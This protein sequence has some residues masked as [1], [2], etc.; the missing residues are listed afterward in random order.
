MSFQ[1]FEV[2]VNGRTVWLSAFVWT[3]NG[4]NQL[5]NLDFRL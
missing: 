2:D 3:E 4:L 1:M 5:K